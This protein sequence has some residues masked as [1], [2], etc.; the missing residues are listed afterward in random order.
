MARKTSENHVL[1]IVQKEE[2]GREKGR[3]WKEKEGKKA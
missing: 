1:E 3:E 2:C